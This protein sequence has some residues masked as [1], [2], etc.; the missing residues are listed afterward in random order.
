MA[1][2]PTVWKNG[3]FPPIDAEHLNKIEQGIVDAVSV[4][5]QSLSDAQKTQAR[6]NI[7]AAPGGYGLGG[8]H[9]SMAYKDTNG[10]DITATGWY[11]IIPQIAGFSFGYSLVRQENYDYTYAVQTAYLFDATSGKGKNHV[12]RR[13]KEASTW[14]PWEWVN[15]P[16]ELGTEYRTTERY[17]GKPVYVKK[18][19]FGNAPAVSIKEVSCATNVAKMVDFNITVWNGA[20]GQENTIIN[21]DGTLA[22]RPYSKLS[23]GTLS[24]VLAVFTD[25]S[26]RT[27]DLVVKYTK[28]TD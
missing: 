14:Y 20:F 13:V 28:T 15:P 12:L 4:T 17:L 6:T 9:P 25:I 27:V 3:E 10:D 7:N 18:V 22:A 11:I 2:T 19:D 26:T 16:M 23:E 1:Y 24:I 8:V 5:P 21:D